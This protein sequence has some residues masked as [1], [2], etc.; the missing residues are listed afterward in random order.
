MARWWAGAA[1]VPVM[2]NRTLRLVATNG[3][4]TAA[5]GWAVPAELR[6]HSFISERKA[7]KKVDSTVRNVAVAYSPVGGRGGVWVV[8]ERLCLLVVNPLP[9]RV[10]LLNHPLRTKPVKEIISERQCKTAGHRTGRENP[11]EVQLWKQGA[12]SHLD[13]PLL[14]ADDAL[15]ALRPAPAEEVS[16]RVLN[17]KVFQ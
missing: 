10:Q 15:P 12:L 9:G 2:L 3:P 4:K 17:A 7:E 8:V 14:T 16:R 6:A 13:I 11:K 1:W 5:D